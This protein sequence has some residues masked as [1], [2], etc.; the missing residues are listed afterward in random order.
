MII[1]K[2]VELFAVG[3]FTPFQ[4]TDT[5]P[6]GLVEFDALTIRSEPVVPVFTVHPDAAPSPVGW[7][8]SVEL[9]DEK[10]AGA[11]AQPSD[12]DV[13][14][15]ICSDFIEVPV[16][17]K[18]DVESVYVTPDAPPAEVDIVIDLLAI[19]AAPTLTALTSGTSA[20][21]AA[22]MIVLTNAILCC[23]FLFIFIYELQVKI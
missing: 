21:T 9:D 15:F 12:N 8:A 3:L 17:G 4:T 20:N 2:N 1:P 11:E 16:V 10:P 22:T 18:E 14:N 6:D 19:W 5:N 7:D 23:C 13:Q